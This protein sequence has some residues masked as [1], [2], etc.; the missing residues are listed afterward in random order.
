MAGVFTDHP[1]TEAA[2]A[3]S[4]LAVLDL[5]E[6]AVGAEASDLLLRDLSALTLRRVVRLLAWGYRHREGW[7]QEW[8]PL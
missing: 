2:R 8:K 3:E 5:Y 7:K 6:K 4:V 1:R